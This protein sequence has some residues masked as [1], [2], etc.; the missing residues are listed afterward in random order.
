MSRWRSL[1][2]VLRAIAEVW[3]FNPDPSIRPDP[4]AERLAAGGI[5]ALVLT[6]AIGTYVVVV[7]GVTPLLADVPAGGQPPPA[8]PA[9]ASVGRETPSAGLVTAA[10]T[11]TTSRTPY[12][13]TS[14]TPRPTRR[15]TPPAATVLPP[16]PP[17]PPAV[18]TTAPTTTEPPATTEP[19]NTT[20]AP[21]GPPDPPGHG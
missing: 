18:T 9:T 10:P 3:R 12:P 13:S 4:R 17:P 21:P 8:R 15:T 20:P 14:P 6:G 11:G 2:G 1:V 5:G 7:G 19:P 16:P